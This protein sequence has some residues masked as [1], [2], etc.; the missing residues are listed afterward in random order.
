MTSLDGKNQFSMEKNQF[1]MQRLC[2]PKTGNSHTCIKEKIK[3][4]SYVRLQSVNVLFILLNLKLV[5]I[6]ETLCLPIGIFWWKRRW[7]FQLLVPILLF[8]QVQ[9]QSSDLILKIVAFVGKTFDSKIL[10]YKSYLH[11]KDETLLRY[12]THILLDCKF[13]IEKNQ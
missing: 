11:A 12:N 10:I 13:I 2:L 1:S 5:V 4:S 8:L 7:P 9:F 6:N 3:V